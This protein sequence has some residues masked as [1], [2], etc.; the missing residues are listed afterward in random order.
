MKRI[1]CF[2]A[3]LISLSPLLCAL[4]PGPRTASVYDDTRRTI[5]IGFGNGWADINRY[6]GMV[7]TEGLALHPAIALD[8]KRLQFL[9]ETDTFL[10]FEATDPRW[11][12]DQF[13]RLTMETTR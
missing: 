5:S 8:A 11:Y 2:F 13:S 9:R 10:S 1:Y 12:S 6:E 3:T 7:V 4:P